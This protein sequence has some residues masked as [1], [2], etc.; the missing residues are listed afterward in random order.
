MNDLV[1]LPVLTGEGT[2]VGQVS[3]VTIDPADGRTTEL[4]VHDGG[5]FGIGRGDACDASGM[6]AD[7][8]AGSE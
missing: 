7:R 3:G 2:D 5:R 8:G 4:A 1:G 6:M